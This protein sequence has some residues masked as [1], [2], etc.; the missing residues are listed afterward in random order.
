MDGVKALLVGKYQQ[1]V[2][3]SFSGSASDGHGNTTFR[4]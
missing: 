2:L 1:D 4:Q 3:L